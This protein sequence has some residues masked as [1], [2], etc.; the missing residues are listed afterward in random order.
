MKLTKVIIF[1]YITVVTVCLHLRNGE[2]GRMNNLKDEI[3][4]KIKLAKNYKEFTESIKD[5]IK[6][7][8]LNKL[9][10]LFQ[11]NGEPLNL[12]TKDS[13]ESHSEWI[14][15]FN[16]HLISLEVAKLKPIQS[17]ISLQKQLN[18]LL[19][20]KEDLQKYLTDEGQLVGVPIITYGGEYVLD[21]HH[22][23]S[24]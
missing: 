23:W 14:K 8:K 4:E 22:R 20:D 19:E 21:G 18:Y 11:A 1:I 9:N 17:E 10:D 2:Q 7:N 12:N 16:L 5:I 15:K 24:E 13:D 6:K 3:S